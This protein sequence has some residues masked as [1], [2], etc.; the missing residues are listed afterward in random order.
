MDKY[1]TG[2]YALNIHHSGKKDEPSGDWHGA[3][4]DNI[5][6]LPH[7]DVK[8]AGEGCFINTFHIWGDFGVYDDTEHLKNC[9]F[10]IKEKNVYVADYY[11]AILDMV[12]ESLMKY[13]EI[14]N[15]NCITYDCLDNDEQVMLVVNKAKILEKYLN[16]SQ[17]IELKK[18]F[19]NETH[20]EEVRKNRIY[21]Y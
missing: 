3:I 18:W 5:K 17:I 15:L 21:E 13:N 11:R 2:Q 16:S 6:E 8:Y 20:Y 9:N 7:K 1:I 4:W 10:I 19:Y 14:I 12:Y